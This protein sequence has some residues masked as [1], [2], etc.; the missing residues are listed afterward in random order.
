MTDSGLIDRFSVEDTKKRTTF[1]LYDRGGGS[2][3]FTLLTEI[4]DFEHQK[5][6]ITSAGMDEVT[7]DRLVTSLVDLWVETRS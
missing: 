5:T 3:R 2:S 1:S 7:F 6:D 4:N